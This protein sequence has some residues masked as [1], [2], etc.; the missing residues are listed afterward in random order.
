MESKFRGVRVVYK[1]FFLTFFILTLMSCATFSGTNFSPIESIPS[2]KALLYIY[3]DS[4]FSGGGRSHNVFINGKLVTNLYSG[5]YYPYFV[6]PG[7]VIVEFKL[8]PT[9]FLIADGLLSSK[10][11]VLRFHAEPGKAYFAKYSSKSYYN[12]L[13]GPQVKEG[14]ILVSKVSGLSQIELCRKTPE[15]D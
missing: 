8:R 4:A 13:S 15:I 9:L 6:E 2:E 14:L 3:R 10:E 12:A 7:L 11:E 5:G 1:I